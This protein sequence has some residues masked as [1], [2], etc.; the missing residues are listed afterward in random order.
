[1]LVFYLI[2]L[3]VR[4]PGA[5]LAGALLFAVHPVH[6]EAVAWV[7]GRTDLLAAFFMLISVIA[8]VKDRGAP[9][10]RNWPWRVAGVLSF[11][12]ALLSKEVSFVLPAVL[13]AWDLIIPAPGAR[14]AREEPWWGRNRFWITGWGTACAAV[15]LL[16]VVVAGIGFGAESASGG[17]L[18]V[19]D[20]LP[21]ITS[22]IATNVRL[23]AVP[24][25][26]NAFYTDDQLAF[27]A[28]TFLGCA[29]FAIFCLALV[30]M[31]GIPV[32]WMGLAWIGFFL[33][34]TF[35]LVARTGALVAERFLY[36]PSIGLALMVGYGWDALENADRARRLRIAAAFSVVAIV[37]GF[38]SLLRERESLA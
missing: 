4:S 2:T 19:H 20:L 16:R 38:G 12:L 8:W 30:R 6:T 11:A 23:L 1:M 32:V 7:S 27:T 3:M 36:V 17:T 9:A 33:V 5:A 18:M 31:R 21:A 28:L 15:V 10:K 22:V 37:S 34:P 35:N 25:P 14:G 24:W 26:L 13:L 29:L